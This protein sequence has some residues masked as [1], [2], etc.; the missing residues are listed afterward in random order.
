MRQT[1]RE[2]NEESVIDDVGR[3]NNKAELALLSL[4]CST[5]SCVTVNKMSP[6]TCSLDVAIH[7]TSSISYNVNRRQSGLVV[8]RWSLSIKLL[9]AGPVSTCICTVTIL[10]HGNHLGAE[11]ATKVYSVWPSLRG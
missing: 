3:L 10:R 9:Y 1:D 8:T 5:V 7:T 2:T 4:S 6:S 11:P